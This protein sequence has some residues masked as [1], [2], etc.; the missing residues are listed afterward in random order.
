MKTSFILVKTFIL[1]S[2]PNH[3]TFFACDLGTKHVTN[4]MFSSLAIPLT[5]TSYICLYM[6][7]CAELFATVGDIL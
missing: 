4:Y 1:V 2:F 6:P 3:L 5:W 7:G